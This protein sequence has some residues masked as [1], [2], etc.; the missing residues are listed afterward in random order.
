MR[1][2]QSDDFKLMEFELYVFRRE[3]IHTVPE[4]LSEIIDPSPLPPDFDPYFWM[5][6][7][8]ARIIAKIVP[9]TGGNRAPCPLCRSHPEKHAGYLPT[10]L[11]RHLADTFG[12]HTCVVMK[13][14]QT[15]LR[16]QHGSETQQGE[17]R[18]E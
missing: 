15:L 10:G 3:L 1:I 18:H 16:C 2:E 13:A 4:E 17:T 7:A 14:A 9:V 5:E 6:Q 11:E 12:Q 8:A